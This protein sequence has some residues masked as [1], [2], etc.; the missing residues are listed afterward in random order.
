MTNPYQPPQ[1]NLLRPEMQASDLKRY[2]NYVILDSDTVWPARCMKCNAPTDFKKKTN[3]T[4]VNPWIYLSVLINILV[5]VVLALIFQ[6]KF[7]LQL[8]LCETHK[9]RR[10]RFLIAQWS[11][12]AALI[13]MLVVAYTAKLP[14]LFVAAGILFIALVISALVSRLAYIAKYKDGK[15]WLKGI[16]KPFLASL[17]EP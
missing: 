3:L 6:K 7:T 10:Q 17:Q 16:G 8:P 1:S 4:Y 9:I 12:L 14:A 13:G 5:T 15:L 11:G 2:K